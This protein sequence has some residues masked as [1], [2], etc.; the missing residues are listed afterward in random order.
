MRSGDGVW[1]GGDAPGLL[2][3]NQQDYSSQIGNA[4]KI[5]GS[6][7]SR[8]DP[9]VQLA[10]QLDDWTLPEFAHL[11]RATIAAAYG[12][13]NA[14]V[15]QTGYAWLQGVDGRLARVSKV[16]LVN[17]NAAPIEYQFGFMTAA[18]GAGAGLSVRATDDRDN[19]TALQISGGRNAVVTPPPTPTAGIWAVNAFES[20]V[21][22]VKFVLTR[23]TTFLAITGTSNTIFEAGFEWYERD[24]LSSEA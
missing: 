3:Q 22:D 19:V 2:D 18:P 21:I 7:P 6:V 15:G 13:S 23:S 4:L 24:P 20:L 1:E 8:V 5:N 11:R 10:V 14:A 9:R 17:R 12:N 16:I